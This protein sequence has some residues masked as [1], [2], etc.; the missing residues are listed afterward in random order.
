[1]NKLWSEN[2]NIN[3]I[4]N[5]LIFLSAVNFLHLG[6][7]F[8]PIIC[9]ILFIDNKFVFKVN[10]IYC[11]ILLCLFGLS[12][13]A[14]TYNYTIYCVAGL[15]IPMAYYI[16]SNI[17]NRNNTKELIYLISYSQAF[18]LVLNFI[19]ELATRGIIIMRKMNHY[20]IWTK[21]ILSTTA[22]AT[23]IIMLIGCI[24]YIF[25]YEKEKKY[26]NV[27]ISLFVVVM[28][29]NIALGRRTPL[30]I[31]GI[32]L[33]TGLYLD[34]IKYKIKSI[35]SKTY[36]SIL[37]VLLG[38]I[39]LI[40]VIYFFNIFGLKEIINSLNIIDKLFKDGF[41]SDRLDLFVQAIKLAPYHLWGKQEISNII[42]I[43]VHD[44]WMD[45]YDYAGIITYLL[46]V[47]H[48]IYFIN[49]FIIVIKRNNIDNKYKV[50][51]ITLFVAIT[52][53]MLLEPIMS[54]SSIFLIMT[55]LIE[56]ALEGM[57]H[58]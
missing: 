12:F 35:N 30:L 54:G 40:G 42:G 22:L 48:T 23:N 15:F 28:I 51:F 26:K 8:I 18:H 21:D 16:G 50:L 43:Y 6:Q 33:I 24:V 14:F 37:L 38:C 39:G 53:Q 55:I 9:L 45:T 13:L 31:L 44:L 34:E 29:Y 52:I 20:D 2:K 5:V 32:V 10:N 3:I 36:K 56:A 25:L 11:F 19:Y 1:M 41:H 57:I 58:E 17:K 27:G 46:L 47:I 7:I 49:I 4:I